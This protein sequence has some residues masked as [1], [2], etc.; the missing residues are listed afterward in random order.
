M[1]S[2]DEYV[3][4]SREET[5]SFPCILWCISPCEHLEV[6]ESTCK[7]PVHSILPHSSVSDSVVPISCLKR[8]K[9]MFYSGSYWWLDP[10]LFFLEWGEWRPSLSFLMEFCLYTKLVVVFIL[11]LTH[12]VRWVSVQASFFSI[13]ESILCLWIMDCGRREYSIHDKVSCF[14]CF[15]MSLISMVGSSVLLCESSLGI[16]CGTSGFWSW[17]SFL[18]LWCFNDGSI[19]YT[20]FRDAKPELCEHTLSDSENTL[21]HSRVNQFIT[22][23]TDRGF[24]GNIWSLWNREEFL[25]TTAI[26]YLILYF[27]IWESIESLEEE[28][29]HQTNNLS[30][31]TTDSSFYGVTR[32][33]NPTYE[34]S[35][36]NYLFYFLKKLLCTSHSELILEVIEKREF[37][38]LRHRE[39]W[40]ENRYNAYA[41]YLFILISKRKSRDFKRILEGRILQRTPVS[42]RASGMW[43]FRAS[44]VRF[45]E[46]DHVVFQSYV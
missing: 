30:T 44:R 6:E 41:L 37:V 46:H 28:Y 7:E 15:N 25:E 1:L 26:S 35:P 13:Q 4:F 2:I 45:Q 33:L 43:D 21:L 39:V 36:W 20:P 40:K 42:Y 10:V 8:S 22:E 24:I 12:A 32:W 18:S 27:W 34:C 11:V 9:W 5:H 16:S 17:H 31:R 38:D 29:L 3:Y 14:W 19:L 23:S